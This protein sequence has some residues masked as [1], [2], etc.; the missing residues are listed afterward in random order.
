MAA[1]LK[2]MAKTPPSFT[3]LNCRMFCVAQILV[4]FAVFYHMEVGTVSCLVIHDYRSCFLCIVLFHMEIGDVRQ[5]N[6]L[7]LKTE[8]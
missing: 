4:L 8:I 2:I 7:L 3:L 1:F 5:V 6:T